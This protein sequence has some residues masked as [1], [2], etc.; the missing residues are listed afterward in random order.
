MC[1]FC[2]KYQYSWRGINSKKVIS[3]WFSAS[4]KGTRPN[5]EVPSLFR[6]GGVAEVC[7]GCV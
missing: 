4:S 3:L 2:E 5:L 1:P 7:E 6:G